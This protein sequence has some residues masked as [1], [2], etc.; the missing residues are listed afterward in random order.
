MHFSFCHRRAGKLYHFDVSSV[1]RRTRQRRVACD[2]RGVQS[3]SERNIRRVIGRQIRPELPDSGQEWRV[4]VTDQRKARKVFESGL[5]A[6]GIELL[7]QAVTSYPLRNFNVDEMGDVQR[8][9]VCKQPR[10][11]TPCR[12]S[13]YQNL[14]HG[15]GINN[16]HRRSRSARITFAGETRGWN[17]WRLASRSR[18]SASEG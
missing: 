15:R 7:S 3:F 18:S 11:D 12:W 10:T 14:Q 16:D 13:Y 5:A 2:Q 6:S 17:G 4:R 8:L 1:P 9:P